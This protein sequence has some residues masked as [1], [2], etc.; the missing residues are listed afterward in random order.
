MDYP[1]TID[2]A[3]YEYIKLE[4]NTIEIKKQNK[5]LAYGVLCSTTFKV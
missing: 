2:L 1:D 3:Q 4:E 5:I